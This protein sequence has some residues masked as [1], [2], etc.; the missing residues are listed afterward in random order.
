MCRQLTRLSRA[1]SA[2]LMLHT[3]PQ[4]KSLT[5]FQRKELMQVLTLVQALILVL[6]Y[7]EEKLFLLHND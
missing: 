2:K 3:K 1:V 4:M 6:S 7:L 5:S